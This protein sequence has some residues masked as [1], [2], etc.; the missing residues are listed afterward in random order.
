M[1]NI[2]LCLLNLRFDKIYKKQDK[3]VST[4]FVLLSWPR[5]VIRQ[6]IKTYLYRPIKFL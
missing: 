3:E 2:I 5:N 4:D 1:M 6:F